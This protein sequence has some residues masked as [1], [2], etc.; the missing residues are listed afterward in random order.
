MSNYYRKRHFDDAAIKCGMGES[1]Y[2][3]SNPDKLYAKNHT[4][5][6][7]NR[8]PRCRQEAEDWC[9]YDPK[10]CYPEERYDEVIKDQDK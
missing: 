1:I 3:K 2:Q 4:E 8:V 5:S 7:Y 9:I 6:F 10:E